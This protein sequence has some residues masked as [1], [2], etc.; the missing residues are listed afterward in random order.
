MDWLEFTVEVR[1][2]K[3]RFHGHAFIDHAVGHA[4]I[5][6]TATR[7]ARNVISN[8]LW[9]LNVTDRYAPDGDTVFVLQSDRA[10]EFL[11]AQFKRVA[12]YSRIVQF[13]TCP[14]VHPQNSLVERYNQTLQ[15]LSLIHI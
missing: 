1:G 5:K 11:A 10:R 9:Y 15:R 6:C 7:T 14:Y 4:R 3:K 12:V 8:V 13:L 2:T